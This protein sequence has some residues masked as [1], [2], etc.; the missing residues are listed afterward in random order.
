[1]LYHLGQSRG[2]RSH[3]FAS[4]RREPVVSAAFIVI[5]RIRPVFVAQLDDETL[6]QHAFDRAIESA[7]AQPHASAGSF[8][9]VLHDCVAVLISIRECDQD[10]EDL[11]RQRQQ[12]V[13][14]SHA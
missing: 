8:G 3:N 11:R 5:L 4:E 13:W 2:F 14:I 7:G 1:L 10:V 6:F 9:Y 12:A